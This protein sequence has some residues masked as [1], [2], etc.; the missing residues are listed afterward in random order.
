MIYHFRDLTD[1][2]FVVDTAKMRWGKASSILATPSLSAAEKQLA[3]YEMSESGDLIPMGGGV[4]NF[5]G[6]TPKDG[7]SSVG[8]LA[9]PYEDHLLIYLK[10]N[11][12]I[13]EDSFQC[14]PI[15][16]VKFSVLQEPQ[17]PT[18]ILKE[19]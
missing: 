7:I 12:P 3:H 5:D 4:Y 11:A 14:N 2:L 16:T 8:I 17:K 19:L 13:K 1:Q 10:P 6:R 9:I 18:A 15:R